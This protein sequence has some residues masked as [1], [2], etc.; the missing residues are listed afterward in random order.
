[1]EKTILKIIFL[2]CICFRTYTLPMNGVKIAE[3]TY[4]KDMNSFKMITFYE[5][6]KIRFSDDENNNSDDFLWNH[7]F[8][9]SINTDGKFYQ[10]KIKNENYSKS[11]LMLLSER[12]L[13]LYGESNEPLFFG[14]SKIN[15]ELLYF[16]SYFEASSKL[17]EKDII[18]TIIDVY[19]GEKYTDTC[20]NA[21]ILKY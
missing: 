11:L 3:P 1:M 10:L 7:V 20:L 8:E 16:P 14:A 5:N 6:N 13:V 15:T 17:H 21:I 2:L 18:L 19:K 9:Y 4:Y 12:F